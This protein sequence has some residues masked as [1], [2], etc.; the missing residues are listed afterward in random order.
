MNRRNPFISI[1][2]ATYRRGYLFRRCLESVI[3]AVHNVPEVM[4]EVI[5]VINIHDEESRKIIHDF[6]GRHNPSFMPVYTQMISRGALRNLGVRNAT[7][8]FIYFIDDDVELPPHIINVIYKKLQEKRDVS[9]IGG[10]NISRCYSTFEKAVNLVLTSYLGTAIVRKRYVKAQENNNATDKELILCN[11]IVRRSLF[12]SLN[13]FFEEHVRCNEENIFLQRVSSKGIK[14]H[15]SPDIFVYH[16]RRSNFFSFSRQN[17]TYGYG[18][19][20]NILLNPA[21]FHVAFIIP[22]LF[23]LYLLLV[24]FLFIV[25]RNSEMFPMVVL[26]L[27]F[28]MFIC[29]VTVIERLLKGIV[30]IETSLLSFFLFFVLHI[31]YG[32]GIMWGLI[33]Y[34]L[35]RYQERPRV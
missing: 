30:D 17:V 26:P 14:L 13:I 11:L 12:Y 8:E 24:F 3:V 33:R 1:V 2:V 35:V 19:A 18:R 5:T 31:S 7:G 29:F 20:Q 16:R 4:V 15:Y 28:Y 9:V 23:I 6:K 22:S 25:C 27:C 21:S 32:I 10:P 34:G